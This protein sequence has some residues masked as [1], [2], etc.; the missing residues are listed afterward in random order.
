MR[1]SPC[2]AFHLHMIHGLNPFCHTLKP[3]FVEY[4]K[5]I[6]VARYHCFTV[7]RSMHLNFMVLDAQTC[8][9]YDS[10]SQAP[11]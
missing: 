6:V 11:C 3:I 7:C 2:V 5:H 1:I 9:Q 4:Y 8:Q 10:Q